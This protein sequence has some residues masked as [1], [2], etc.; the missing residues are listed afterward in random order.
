MYKLNGAYAANA[1]IDR[2]CTVYA[3]NFPLAAIICS[4]S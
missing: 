4:K 2:I 1:V 3:D